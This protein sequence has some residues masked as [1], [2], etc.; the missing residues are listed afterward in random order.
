M[1]QARFYKVHRSTTK[2][3]WLRLWMALLLAICAWTIPAAAQE[4][5]QAY[6]R[7][8]YT[9]WLEQYANAKP[10]FKP[11]DTLTA[12]DI[13][14]LRPF[15]IPGY[16][17]YL[18]FP[19]FKAHIISPI[20]HTP[21]QAFIAC[22]EKYH[23]QVRLNSDGAMQNYV[24]GQPFLNSELKIEDPLSGVKAGWN[25][26]WKWSYYG[27][28]IY[29][30]PWIWVRFDGSKSHT[31]PELIP[32][33]QNLVVMDP[34]NW[35]L[36]TDL[37]SYYQGG[38]TFQRTLQSNYQHLVYSHLATLNGGALPVPGAQDFEWKE[39]TVFYAPFD[40]RG[41]GFLI[42]RYSDPYRADDA[43]A[44]IPTLRRVRRVSVETKYDSLL[45]TDHTLDDFYGYAG[46]VLDMDWKFLGYKDILCVCDPKG[47][48]D[49]VYGPDGIVP[50]ED[51]EVR[52][53]I[54]LERIPRNPRHPYSSAIMFIDP[55]IWYDPFHVAF[56]HSG[57]LWKLFQ[58]QW[59]WTETVPPP[60]DKYN[61]GAQTVVWQAVNDM[62]VQN[63]RGTIIN[64]FGDGF[65]NVL[66]DAQAYNRRY[67]VNMLEELHR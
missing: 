29:H 10:D 30:I 56:D 35:S 58:W 11:G 54:V 38:G 8:D 51:W 1:R 42:Y 33:A 52:K 40:I 65:P 28:E 31:L 47:M 53:M 62:D 13:E 22:T 61:K 55:Q 63:N 7:A 3:S 9:K 49:H 2:A 36:P 50:D 59:K 12:N 66:T 57:K 37:T 34:G 39:L 6:T 23:G 20:D 46:R 15:V 16:L 60:W 48:H 44:Y 25:W 4:P 67:E 21:H 24:C 18:N 43:W 5:K 19:E 27:L 45:G 26:N 64:A 32:P 14:R 17:E 41:T